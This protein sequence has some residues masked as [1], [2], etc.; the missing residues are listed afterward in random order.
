MS[1]FFSGSLFGVRKELFAGQLSPSHQAPPQKFDAA[2]FRIAI[3]GVP[4][5][6]RGNQFFISSL[7]GIQIGRLEDARLSS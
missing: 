6:G 5:W 4:V 7:N 3:S 1:E 2:A